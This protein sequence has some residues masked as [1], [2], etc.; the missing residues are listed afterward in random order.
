MPIDVGSGSYQKPRKSKKT[1]IGTPLV[2]TKSL[3]RG[4]KGGSG[5]SA[6]PAG[7]RGSSHL[8]DGRAPQSVSYLT[9]AANASYKARPPAPKTKDTPWDHIA[10][11]GNPFKV[12]EKAKNLR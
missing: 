12:I 7:L 11:A 6:K 4:G 8:I 2:I 1:E 5:L 10:K 3:P 9:K